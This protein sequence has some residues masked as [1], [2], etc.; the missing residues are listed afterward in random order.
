MTQQLPMPAAAASSVSLDD[1]AASP[2]TAGRG[3]SDPGDNHPPRRQ[4][5]DDEPGPSSSK[6]VK[7]GDVKPLCCC[8]CLRR[9]CTDGNEAGDEIS[10]RYLVVDG[11]RSKHCEHCW[12]AKRAGRHGCVPM[13]TALVPR[14]NRLW[15]ANLACALGKVGAPSVE[16]IQESAD[17]L[18]N[19][20][21]L[22][23][24]DAARRT[25][26]RRAR[27]PGARSGR[28]A[29]DIEPLLASILDAIRAAVDSYREVNRLAGRH[30]PEEDS[31]PESEQ[32]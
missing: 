9:L 22:A 18:S 15:E 8:R 14:A 27:A 21:R 19:D 29:G 25:A 12:E 17:A 24:V 1:Y 10:C 20:M 31:D 32:D 13:P 2:S 3:S 4:L 16:N 28:G 6:R 7:T 23:G 5:P 26:G 30:W 11:E